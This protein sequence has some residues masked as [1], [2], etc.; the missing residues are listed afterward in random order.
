MDETEL[1]ERF[2]DIEFRFDNIQQ[3]AAEYFSEYDECLEDCDLRISELEKIVFNIAKQYDML[4]DKSK[5]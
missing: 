1:N 2:E 4:N 5:E 3:L